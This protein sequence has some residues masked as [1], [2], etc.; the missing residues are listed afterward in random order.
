MLNQSVHN[1]LQQIII[2]QQIFGQTKHGE[3]LN[4]Q[5]GQRDSVVRVFDV[6]APNLII[7]FCVQNGKLAFPVRVHK[8]DRYEE[9]VHVSPSALK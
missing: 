1:D 5:I 3:H 8:V 7:V 4:G 2:G 9:L 6:I